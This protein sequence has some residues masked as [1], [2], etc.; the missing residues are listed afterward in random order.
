MRINSELCGRGSGAQL[1]CENEKWI[2]FFGGPPKI[3]A[4]PLNH[5]GHGIDYYYGKR[6]DNWGHGWDGADGDGN[7]SGSGMPYDFRDIH[8][9][10]SRQISNRKFGNLTEHPGTRA[11]TWP[12]G[13]PNFWENTIKEALCFM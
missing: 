1:K 9:E 12:G 13:F 5:I 10:T 11:T 4:Q 8:N 2:F 6:P 7:G 3:T